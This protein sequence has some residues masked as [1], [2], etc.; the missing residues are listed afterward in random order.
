MSRSFSSGSLASGLLASTLA[1]LF[2]FPWGLIG[3]D[4][5][6]GSATVNLALGQNALLML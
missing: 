1:V 6:V 4:R 3:Q 5:C 2:V